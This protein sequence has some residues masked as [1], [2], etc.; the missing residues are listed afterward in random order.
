MLFDPATLGREEE[1]G[2]TCARSKQGGES[3]DRREEATT[4]NATGQENA[5]DGKKI[6]ETRNM[7]VHEKTRLPRTL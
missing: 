2:C 5:H 7:V 1:K 6:T 4:K 3:G